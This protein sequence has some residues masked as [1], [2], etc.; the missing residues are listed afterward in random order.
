M[1]GDLDVYVCIYGE[2]D[3]GAG[4]RGFDER[5]PVPFQD[6]KNGGKNVL[7]VN[8][9][10]FSFTDETESVGLGANNNRWSFSASWEDYDNDGDPDLYVANDFGRNCMYR[11]DEGYF[12]EDLL[13]SMAGY[14]TPTRGDVII[15]DEDVAWSELRKRIGVVH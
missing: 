15:G 11:N 14:V 9:G 7:L 5:A 13:M 1:D 6:A 8:R 2:G 3:R 10:G 4:S 12:T